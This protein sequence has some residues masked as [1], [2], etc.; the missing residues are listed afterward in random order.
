MQKGKKFLSDLKL[1]SD[2][3]KWRED[4]SRFETW[5][6]ACDSIMDGH[7]KKY[8][9]VMSPE[10]ETLMDETVDLMKAKIILASQRSLQFRN[11]QITKHNSKMYNCTSTYIGYNE[12]FQ[13]IFYLGLS[14]CGVGGGLLLPFVNNISRIQKRTKGTITYI[15][16]DSIEGWAD[17][18]GVLMSSFFVD[19]QPFPE[20][21]GYQI[22]FD[23]SEIRPKGALI[24]GG[25]KAPGPEGLQDAL[26]KIEALLNKW[27]ETEGNKIRPILAFD[28]ICH[29]SDAVLSGG[30]RRSALN[31]VVDPNDKEMI[32]A[33]TGNWRKENPQRARSNNS[34]LL[35]RREVTKEQFE[36]LVLLNEGDSDIGFVF[37]NSWFDMFNPCF[38]I[39]KIPMLYKGHRDLESY[40]Y[41]ELEA[42]VK[43][44]GHTFGVQGCNLSEINAEECTTR[45][46]FLAACVGASIIGTLQA[47]YTSFPY[48]GKTTEEIFRREALIGVSITGWM[49]NPKLFNRELLKRGAEMVKE[50]NELIAE[51]IGINPAARTTCVKPSGNASVILGTASGIHPDHSRFLFR[52]MQLNKESD[53]AKWLQQNMP[54]LLEESVWSNTNSDY[55]VY[56]PIE[57]PEDGLF[58]KD[59]KGVKHLELIKLVQ[60]AWVNE[61]TN[62]ERCVYPNVNHN[63]S[64][65]VIIDNKKEVIDYIWD[66]KDSFTAVSFISDYGDK[67][68]NQ[69]PF[70]AV[71]SLEELVA[72]YGKGVLFVSGLIVDG[73]HYFNENLWEACDV[74]ANKDIQLTGTREQVMLRK[75]WI[76]RVK[77]FAHNFFNGDLQK[78]IYCIKD[79]HLLHKWEVI[80]RKFKPVDFSKVLSKPRYKE[81][82]NYAAQACSGGTC[83]ITSIN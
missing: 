3:L 49:N 38:E 48:L 42:F 61:G 81:I 29:A 4:D 27:I 23:Y 9:S 45:E 22:K 64:N 68:F 26:E 37:A 32:Y 10:L 66:N 28:I 52:I 58:K 50:A 47:G 17:S 77:Q 30:V 31:M 78:T 79:V 20:Y 36:L 57:N 83:E 59:M 39:L 19:K 7:R 53:T 62:R 70:T 56:V 74:V 24:S 69:A 54:Y 71:S 8:N 1:Y 46:K 34:V 55:V 80:N 13:N 75:Y 18:L 21:A 15:I 72:K 73:L 43:E 25:F 51:V 82:S 5:E 40:E 41:A 6:E 63:T 11:D 35:L 12:V 60:E 16:P 33:K 44:Y 14:G 2:Y 67:D 65:T 76:R